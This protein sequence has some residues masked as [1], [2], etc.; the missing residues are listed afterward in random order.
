[1][2]YKIQPT[3]MEYTV[4]GT[5]CWDYSDCTNQGAICFGSSET[6]T[7]MSSS[8]PLC[9]AKPQLLKVLYLPQTAPTPSEDQVFK[10]EAIEN[11]LHSSQ[12]GNQLAAQTRRK[13]LS[14]T[15]VL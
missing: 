3:L 5:C 7:M 13:L 14:E 15:T 6:V 12:T 4:M 10:H 11:I 8:N 2:A 1:M 9:S